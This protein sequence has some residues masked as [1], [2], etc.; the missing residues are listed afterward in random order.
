MISP[1]DGIVSQI[2]ETSGPSELDLEKEFVP[3]RK[4]AVC[5]SVVKYDK[6]FRKKHGKVFQAKD[7]IDPMVKAN[8]DKMVDVLKRFG[9]CD[10]GEND[11]F[12]KEDP[13]W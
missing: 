9:V 1:A 8:Y 10:Y 5:A 7:N 6:V 12:K 4:I 2:I 11:M 13:N 3:H